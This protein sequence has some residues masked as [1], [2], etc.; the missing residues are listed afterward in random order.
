[1]GSLLAIAITITAGVA[2]FS[3]VNNQARVTEGQ[4]G[5]SVGTTVDYLQ[6]RFV[7]VDMNF[8][9][10]QLTVWF[11]NN[12]RVALSPIQVILYSSQRTRYVTYNAT[13]IVSSGDTKCTVTPPGSDES[14][15]LWNPKTSSGLQIPIQSI[16]K[17]TLVLPCS[18]QTFVSGTTYAVNVLGLYGNTVVY[19]QT[20]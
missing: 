9:S 10:T 4:Y 11:Y 18:G 2:V 1:M 5:A 15:L 19:Y 6:E 12:G 8:T 13:A 16:Q 17:L 20:R 7:I 14:P 3:Y